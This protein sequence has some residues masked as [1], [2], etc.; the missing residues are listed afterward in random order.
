MIPNPAQAHA[1][2]STTGAAATLAGLGFAIHANTEKL[3]IQA[4]GGDV[5][6]TLN[7]TAPTASLGLKVIDGDFIQLGAGEASV[8]KFITGSG[9][10]KLEIASYVNS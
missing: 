6:M 10:P 2:I 4:V 5:R 1:S 7:G 3:L 9:T 8:A